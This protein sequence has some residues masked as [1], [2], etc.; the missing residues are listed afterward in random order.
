MNGEVVQF[1]DTLRLDSQLFET[2]V[3]REV[4]DTD[5]ETQVLDDADCVVDEKDVVLDSDGERE[6]GTEV[7]SSDNDDRLSDDGTSLCNVKDSNAEI[8]I[9]DGAAGSDKKKPIC[10]YDQGTKDVLVDS[11][12]STEDD[13]SSHDQGTDLIYIFIYLFLMFGTVIT[14]FNLI[15]TLLT[16]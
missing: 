3:V 7:L 10:F 4:N 1:D 12:A 8:E 5:I 2:E 6:E 13:Y 9:K 15:Q 11:D 14:R 16:D